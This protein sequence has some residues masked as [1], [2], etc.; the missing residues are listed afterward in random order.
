[1]ATTVAVVG[2]N[3]VPPPIYLASKA[4]IRVE[5]GHTAW[6]DELGSDNVVVG[7]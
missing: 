1:M 7:P 4:S 3:C 6:T 2:C 5:C